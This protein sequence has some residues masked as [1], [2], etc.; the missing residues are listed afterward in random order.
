MIALHFDKQTIERQVYSLSDWMNEVGGFHAYMQ[1]I[2]TL[3]LPIFQVWSLEKHI[4]RKIYR[5]QP[6]FKIDTS[7]RPE[8]FRLAEAASAL[9]G[10]EQIRPPKSTLIKEWLFGCLSKCVRALRRD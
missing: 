6:S 4:L 8:Q 1:L 5:L 3:L 10:R 9:K 2:V 7:L